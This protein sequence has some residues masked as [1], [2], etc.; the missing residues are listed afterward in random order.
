M[1]VL[2]AAAHS[3]KRFVARPIRALQRRMLHLLLERGLQDTA[4]QVQ[5][6]QLGVAT[7]ARNRYEVMSGDEFA[8][9][10]PTLI[11]LSTRG[12]P[13]RRAH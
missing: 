11:A 12:T 3:V 10:A 7:P 9:G 8:F 2:R 4:S 13:A 6:E 5:L 1:R